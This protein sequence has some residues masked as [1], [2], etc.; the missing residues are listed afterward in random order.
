MSTRATTMI[1]LIIFTI[2]TMTL[3][4]DTFPERDRRGEKCGASLSK[5]LQLS[6]KVLYRGP[7]KSDDFLQL[8]FISGQ[9][10]SPLELTVFAIFFPLM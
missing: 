4:S 7:Q 10:F 6:K 3:V 9:F 2:P 8:W 1:N 5:N